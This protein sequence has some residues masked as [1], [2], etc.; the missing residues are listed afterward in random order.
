MF[1]AA[2][3]S[4][5]YAFQYSAPDITDRQ[6]GWDLFD[7]QSEY[8]RMGVPNQNWVLTSINKEYEV[9]IFGVI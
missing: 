3:L 5:L 6:A 9:L 4:E 2:E 7:L 1:V 8:L